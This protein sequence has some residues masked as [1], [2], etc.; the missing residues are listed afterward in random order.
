MLV[1]FCRNN[2]EP[3]FKAIHH[4]TNANFCSPQ[5]YV[6]AKN[7]KSGELIKQNVTEQHYFAPREAGN[8][9]KFVLVKCVL[10]ADKFCRV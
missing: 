6:G 5:S 10:A 8:L 1:N 2:R 7:C 9:Q 3:P 4:F